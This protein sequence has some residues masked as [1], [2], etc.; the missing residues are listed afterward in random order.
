MLPVPHCMFSA[1]NAAQNGLSVL[2]VVGSGLTGLAADVGGGVQELSRHQ[3]EGGLG[4]CVLWSV[5]S[6]LSL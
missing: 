4:L 1:H 6:W 2:A 3:V 5:E